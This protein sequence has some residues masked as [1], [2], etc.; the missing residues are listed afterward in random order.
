VR[1]NDG[2]QRMAALRVEVDPATGPGRLVLTGRG[3]R[4]EQELAASGTAAFLGL[5]RGE[6]RLDWVAAG[7]IVASKQ[8]SFLGPVRAEVHLIDGDAAAS[9]RVGV[10]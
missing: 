4:R 5:E 3:L 10:R 2:R 9:Q 8:L 7:H 1:S 6:Y